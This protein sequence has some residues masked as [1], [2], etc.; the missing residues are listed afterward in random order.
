[1]CPGYRLL[2]TGHCLGKIKSILGVSRHSR[3]AC[4]HICLALY[5]SS[6]S[7]TQ[8]SSIPAPPNSS[9]SPVFDPSSFAPIEQF[10]FSPSFNA[11]CNSFDSNVSC[12]SENSRTSSFCGDSPQQSQAPSSPNFFHDEATEADKQPIP[13]RPQR[14]RG[15][16]RHNCSNPD[17]SLAPSKRPHSSRMP[18]NQVERKYREGLNAELEAKVRCPHTTTVRGR[19]NDGSSQ[20]NQ[21]YGFCW[22]H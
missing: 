16:S 7:R 13:R 15:R 2:F 12:Q 8:N 11:V 17:T 19:W 18:H 14:K 20:T 21:S 10:P 22:R 3:A 6:W 9:Y 4:H 5:P 1:M